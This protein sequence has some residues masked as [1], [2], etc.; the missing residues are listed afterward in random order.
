MPYTKHGEFKSSAVVELSS[1][2][3]S[4]VNG[5]IVPLAAA[6]A[7]LATTAVIGFVDGI[8]TGIKKDEMRKAAKAG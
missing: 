8:F 7:I 2:E 5:G 4:E 3:V 1:A 6:G